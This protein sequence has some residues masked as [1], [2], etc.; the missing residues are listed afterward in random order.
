MHTNAVCDPNALRMQ[1]QMRMD[2]FGGRAILTADN[3]ECKQFVNAFSCGMH[4]YSSDCTKNAHECIHE[5]MQVS[6]NA[7]LHGCMSM[8]VNASVF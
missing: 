1:P 5:R 3:H 8:Y 2:A 4:W 6:Y 7:F